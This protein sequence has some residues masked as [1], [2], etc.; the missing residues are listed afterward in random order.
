MLY[1]INKNNEFLHGHTNRHAQN[2]DDL[3]LLNYATKSNVV[4]TIIYV[5]SILILLC[6]SFLIL[7]PQMS[8]SGHEFII[9][10]SLVEKLCY[11]S[12]RDDKNKNNLFNNLFLL[13]I[14]V[15]SC[16]SWLFRHKP[17][18]VFLGHHHH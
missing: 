3:H 7:K 2:L 13:N 15:T 8:Y 1:Y 10:K 11:Y 5:H 4:C 17:Y 12:F 14:G 18:F 6:D 9:S 16:Y